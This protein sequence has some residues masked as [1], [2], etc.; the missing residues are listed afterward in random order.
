MIAEEIAAEL[1]LDLSIII[2]VAKLLEEL[3]SYYG[4]PPV[5]GDILAGI[6]LGPSV[7]DL[8]TPEIIDYLDVIKWIGIISLLFLAGM[9]TKFTQFMRSLKNSTI[10]AIGGIVGSFVLGYLAGIF[11]GLNSAQSIFLGTILTATSVGLTVKTLS[12]LGAIGTRYF[13]IILGAAVLDDVGGLIVFGLAIAVV[14]TGF[15][16]IEELILTVILAILFYIVIM[17]TL[18]KSSRMIWGI[19][20]HVSHLE[21]SIIAFLLGLTLIIAWASVKFNLSLVIGAYVVGLAFSEIRGVENVIHRF[22][23]IP[24]IFASIFFVLSA[25]SIDIKPYLMHFEYLGFIS[26][27]VIAAI[28]GK[29]LG[30]GLAAKLSKLDWIS[31]LFIGFGMLPRAEVALVISALGKGYNVVTDSM[32]AATIFMIYVTSIITPLILAS[33]WGRMSVNL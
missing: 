11:A 30:C 18:H 7:L 21:D 23:L 4:Y 31:S 2:I 5:L 16:R 27:V 9:E 28:V 17:F 15:A 33:L 32:I 10:I 14:T 13:T 12:D 26:I 3:I 20:K 1:L 25:A 24:N 22:S 19:L 29:V 8:L 6:I